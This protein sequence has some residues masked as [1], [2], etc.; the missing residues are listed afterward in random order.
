MNDCLLSAVLIYSSRLQTDKQ[1]GNNVIWTED[2]V[3]S[4]DLI[5]GCPSDKI[6]SLNIFHINLRLNYMCYI[7]KYLVILFQS[8]SDSLSH[9][10]EQFSS[11]EK[12]LSTFL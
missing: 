2:V 9:K 8:F 1:N 6:W 4:D 5:S 7:K 10:K 11:L 12:G 3:C